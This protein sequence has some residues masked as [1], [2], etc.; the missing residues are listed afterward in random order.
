MSKLSRKYQYFVWPP[1]FSSTALTLLVMEFTRVSQVATG[2]IFQSSITTSQSW[3]MLET[4]CSSTFHLKMSHRWF[5]SGDMLGQSITFTLSFFSKAVVILE[6]CLGS[7]SCW[8]TSLWPTFQR[9]V[10]LLNRCMATILQLS[11]RVL[12]IFLQPRPSLCWETIL[13]FISLESSMRCHVKL[14]VTS[15]RECESDNTKFNTPDPCS[16]LRPCKTDESHD[17]WEGKWLIWPSL[18]IF[19]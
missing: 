15:M 9:G 6:V 2:I 3:W 8:N 13:F 17:P 4:L 7:F 19:T 12:A 10:I 18:D 14:P 5:R 1:L 16:H 11:F